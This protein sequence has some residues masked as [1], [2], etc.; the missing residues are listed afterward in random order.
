MR[1]VVTSG[2]VQ[3]VLHWQSLRELPASL[4]LGGPA[5]QRA[6]CGPSSF[7]PACLF[8]TVPPHCYRLSVAPPAFR[9]TRQ[10]KGSDIPH[11][12]RTWTELEKQP[13][14]PRH[15]QQQ[16]QQ[17]SSKKKHKAAAGDD[18]DDDASRLAICG[19]R[20]LSHLDANGWGTP[21]PIQR[22]AVPALLGRREVL[23]VAPTGS[24]KTL[25]FLLPMMAV[26]NQV[27]A[28][29]AFVL[30]AL[31]RQQQQHSHARRHNQQRP[32]PTQHHITPCCA[33]L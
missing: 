10:V 33:V 15:Q 19:R 13:A 21:T 7:F 9:E 14:H 26:L 23:A 28:P 16:Q 24:G 22:Q 18:D 8:N 25:A 29:R 4:A 27:R 2:G 31:S 12:L 6:W 5:A 20:L 3:H 32:L 1:S 17:A 30:H 11:P